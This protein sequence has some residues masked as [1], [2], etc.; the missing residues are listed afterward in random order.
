ML[1]CIFIDRSG[2]MKIVIDQHAPRVQRRI[3]RRN[4]AW[5]KFIMR[6]RTILSASLCTQCSA[7]MFNSQH[8]NYEREKWQHVLQSTHTHNGIESES[9]SGGDNEP[10]RMREKASEGKK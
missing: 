3:V 7:V 1:H 8:I 4:F 9:D 2:H 10:G 6:K 5:L